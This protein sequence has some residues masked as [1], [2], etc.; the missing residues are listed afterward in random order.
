MQKLSVLIFCRDDIAK[1][2]GLVKDL[3]DLSDQIVLMDNST[4]GKNLERLVSKTRKY[5]GKVVVYH[6]ISLGYPDPMRAYGLGK[7]KYDWVLYVDTDERINQEL[8]N[9][10]KRII[11]N[12]NCD[13]FAIK[14]YEQAH[15]DG[16][17]GG[18]FT[19]Q[20]RLYNRRK[21]AYRGL[22]HEQP[23]VKGVLKKLEGR[24]CM[25]H[26]EELKAKGSRRTD[27]EYSQIKRYYDRL[28]YG[29]LNERMKEYLEKLVVPDKRIE[30]T[31]IGKIVLGWMRLYQGITFRK[32]GSELST[33]DYFV[34][35]SMIEG[36]YVMKRKD[37][38]YLF[39]EALPT[40]MKDTKSAHKMKKEERSREIFEIS[41]AVN[42]YGMIRYLMLDDDRVV[43]KLNRKYR[44]SKQGIM[45]LM[46]LLEDRYEGN[47]IM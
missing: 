29:M 6:T 33:F 11:G 24:Y 30:D 4:N 12:P 16:R 43:E 17:S 35:F 37:L 44:N 45:L 39:D 7:C 21:V 34:F 46:K 2:V 26:I 20:T 32:T 42:K 1:A 15:L 18:F 10:I 23:L 27:L 8:K 41:K 9:D 3:L 25:L 5:K 28:S 47:Y 31:I 13:A 38:K 19:W 36:A 22:V 40:V 14:R